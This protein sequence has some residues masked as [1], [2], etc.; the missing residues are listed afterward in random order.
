MSPPDGLQDSLGLGFYKDAVPHGTEQGSRK[1]CLFLPIL[2][3]SLLQFREESPILHHV[4]P[5]PAKPKWC[6]VLLA[7]VLCMGNA[8]AI[9]ATNRPVIHSLT[10]VGTNLV[11]RVSVPPDIKQTTLEM[12]ADLTAEWETATALNIPDG[13]GDIEFAIPKP[14][15][16]S[17]FFRMRTLKANSADKLSTEL[18]YV[19][20]PSLHAI[21]SDPASRT[22]A[23]FHFKGVVDG[24][25]RIVINHRGAFWTHVNWRWPAGAV[26]ING[27][28]WKP[29]EKNYLTT[30]GAVAFLPETFSLETARLE[31][32]AGRD[33]IALERTNHALIVLLNDTQSGPSTYEFKIH[34]GP[35]TLKP[36]TLD[37]S[38]VTTLKFAAVI[39]GSD[40]LKITKQAATW[41]HRTYK[42]PWDVS[43]NGVPWNVRQTNTLV[44]AGTNTFL[45][46]DV[47]L[48]SA[49]IIHRKGR[50]VATM[51]FEDDAL[52]IHFADNPNGEDSYELEIAFDIDR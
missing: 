31:K 9:T 15:W 40:S 29:Q 5:N 38:Q 2:F 41:K 28:E 12:R 16:D 50:D 21:T 1:L 8:S 10:L 6:T 33:V 22:N 44:N 51:Q 34:F 11:F 25:D 19:I 24:S 45:P 36:A 37:K 46:D 39:D 43:L 13:G 17:A 3:N 14:T 26:T 7:A 27:A 18:R 47:N 52:Q 48:S 4:S 23:V 30:T 20:I 35:A 49:R 32:I 42:L